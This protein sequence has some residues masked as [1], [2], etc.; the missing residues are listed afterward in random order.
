MASKK[1]FSNLLSLGVSYLFHPLLMP[2]IGLL[3]LFNSGTYLTYIDH[4]IKM[5]TLRLVFIGTFIFPI[6]FLPLLFYRRMVNS[7][8]L[9]ERKERIIPMTATAAFCI[10]VYALLWYFRAPLVIQFFL[11]GSALVVVAATLISVWWKIS[12]HMS[13]L[14]GICGL[15]L[16][17]LLR[18]NAPIIYFFL[19]SVLVAGIVGTA[20]LKL[21]AHTPAQV[22]TG[23]LLGLTFLFALFFFV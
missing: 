20:R 19:I 3:L 15:L 16:G 18:Y 4:E 1:N 13:G 2:S 14:G 22:Y 8:H 11:L 9:G 6:S 12:A 23:F 5:A 7:I 17:L 21:N 10:L